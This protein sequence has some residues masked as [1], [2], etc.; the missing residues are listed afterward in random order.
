MAVEEPE[1]LTSELWRRRDPRPAAPYFKRAED[2][3]DHA[4]DRERGGPIP[5]SW[6]K[7]HGRSLVRYH[8]HPESKFLGG[9]YDQRGPLKRRHV[10]ALG[11]QAISKESDKLEENEFIGEDAGTIEH[12]LERSS[13][14]KISAFVFETQQRCGISDRTLLDR[15]KVSP[16]TIKVLRSGKV[17]GNDVLQR[18]A[19][20]VEE[21]SREATQIESEAEHWLGVARELA[22]ELGGRNRLAEA[23]GVTGPYLGRVLRGIKPISSEL[24]QKL[25]KLTDGR[26]PE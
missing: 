5:S 3:K 16:H 19:S 1:A 12:P 20:A 15:A 2:A 10:R 24:T 8:L 17:V 14:A 26:L 18:L 4:F 6:L 25:Q 21:L 7:S 23:L 9:E 13:A 22:K 11:R